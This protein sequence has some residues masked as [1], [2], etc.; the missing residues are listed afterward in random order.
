[1]FMDILDM[2]ESQGP[3]GVD[4]LFMDVLDRTKCPAEHLVSRH[5]GILDRTKH[6]ARHQGNWFPCFSV[7]K[8]GSVMLG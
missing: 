4:H 3:F 6:P 7:S 2:T 8:A 1:M 5:L